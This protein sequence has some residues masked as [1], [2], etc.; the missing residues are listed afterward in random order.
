[1][2]VVYCLLH[3]HT[4]ATASVIHIIAIIIALLITHLLEQSATNAPLQLV[5]G[6]RNCSCHSDVLDWVIVCLL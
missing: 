1:M 2:S 4:Q 6:A 5:D 3:V